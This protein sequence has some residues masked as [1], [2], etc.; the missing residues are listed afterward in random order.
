[1]RRRDPLAMR[2]HLLLGRFTS[3]ATLL[4]LA[5]LR[6]TRDPRQT[7]ALHAFLGDLDR[8]RSVL[9][10]TLF[11]D[12]REHDGGADVLGRVYFGASQPLHPDEIIAL[13]TGGRGARLGMATDAGQGRTDMNESAGE[14]MN[15]IARDLLDFARLMTALRVP[16]TKTTGRRRRRYE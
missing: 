8:A 13:A 11:R 10:D 2:H 14:T 5:A 3:C 16:E 7:E 4:I 15:R 12:F 1:M 6:E 9:D